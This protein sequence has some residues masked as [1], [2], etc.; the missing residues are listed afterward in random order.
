MWWKRRP[1]GRLGAPAAPEDKRVY[2][3]LAAVV[4]P[5]AVVYPLVGAS[6]IV[7]LGTDLAVRAAVRRLRPQGAVR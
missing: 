6:L 1:K 4:I 3:W 5:L 7:V 2:A